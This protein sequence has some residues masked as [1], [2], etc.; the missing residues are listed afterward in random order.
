MLVDWF[1]R[2]KIKWHRLDP[3]CNV[4]TQETRK[5]RGSGSIFYR[6]WHDMVDID[7]YSITSV[8][9]SVS[10]TTVSP[11]VWYWWRRLSSCRDL[12]RVSYVKTRIPW[13]ITI[14]PTSLVS[15][16]SVFV[17]ENLITYRESS[18]YSCVFGST[19]I[20]LFMGYK[21][22]GLELRIGVHSFCKSF[23]TGVVCLIYSPVTGCNLTTFIHYRV[24]PLSFIYKTPSSYLKFFCLSFLSL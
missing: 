2:P 19:V 12:E 23:Y 22:T 7:L 16:Y 6:E 15:E 17:T 21:V 1:H 10:L 11:N 8:C 20:T 9:V 5:R 3:E 13:R 18:P 4:L 14:L 24:Y